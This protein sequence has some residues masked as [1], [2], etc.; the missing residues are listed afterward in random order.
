[1]VHIQMVLSLYYLYPLYM[2]M[3]LITCNR[4]PI[5]FIDIIFAIYRG[6]G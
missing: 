5:L 1:M 2:F 4:C 3:Y 6:M